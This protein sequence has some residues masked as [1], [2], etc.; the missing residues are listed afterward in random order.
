MSRR[1]NHTIPQDAARRLSGSHDPHVETVRRV[2]R[3]IESNLETPL[4]LAALGAVASLSPAHLQR[5]FKRLTGVSPR[6]YAD[7]C[8]LSLLKSRLRERPTVTT[9]LYEAGYGSSSR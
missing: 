1:P 8:R 3:H 7:A 5:L 4:T 2:C 6:Q 9:A